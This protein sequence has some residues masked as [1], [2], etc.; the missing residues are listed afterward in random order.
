MQ[1]EAVFRQARELI[2]A[3]QAAPS[4]FRQAVSNLIMSCQSA[5]SHP[6]RE[7]HSSELL[8]RVKSLYAARLAICETSE[9]NAPVPKECSNIMPPVGVLLS[10]SRSS[11]ADGSEDD[12]EL[13]ATS[14]LGPCLQALQEHQLYW[15]SYS[16]NRQQATVICQASR[17]EIEKD[18]I[19]EFYRRLTTVGEGI[20][21]VLN[22]A[23]QR[24]AQ[25][26]A[27]QLAKTREIRDLQAWQLEN[28]QETHGLHRAAMSSMVN[29]FSTQLLQFSQ[30][31]Q[32]WWGLAG[33]EAGMV[34]MAC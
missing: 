30:V 12:V 6:G 2:E 15:I 34:R 28:L 32:S 9:G 1:D 19:L 26:A 3:M 29:N 11:L 24:A 16:N 25:D 10:G 17:L 22:E 21:M 14:V 8:E 5:K 18:E 23:H 27:A 13:T 31:L 20:S 33:E 4:C 7:E